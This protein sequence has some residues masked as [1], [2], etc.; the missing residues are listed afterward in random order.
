NVKLMNQAQLAQAYFQ[1]RGLD[2]DA[3]LLQ[4][5]MQLYERSLQLTKDRM[6]AGIASG[7]DVAQAQAQ[8]DSTRAQWIDVGVARA[9]FEHAIA[10]LTGRPPSEVSIP[11]SPLTMLPPPIPVG[12][13]SELLERRP[14]I[15]GAERRMAAANEQIG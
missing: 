10:V 1:L 12:V 7:A 9:Q 14:D 8:Y 15:S 6:D 4:S 13:P 11:P 2:G 5:T 3:Q